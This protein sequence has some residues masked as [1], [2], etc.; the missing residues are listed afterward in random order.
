MSAYKIGFANLDEKNPF[1]VSV[2]EHLEAVAA[3]A[4]DIELIVRDN[5][6]NTERAKANAQEFAALPVDLA[7]MF[8][9]DERAG[10]EIISPLRT[11]RIPV[12]S[13]DIPILTTTFFGIDPVRAGRVAGEAM[14][15]WVNAHWGGEIEKVLVMTEYRTLDIFQQRFEHA[16]EALTERTNFN[17]KHLLNM[18]NGGQ[19]DTAAERVKMVLNG[20]WQEQHKIVIIC[21]NDKIAAGVLDGVRELQREEDVAVLSYDGTDV[22]MAEFQRPGSRFIVSPS[23]RADIYGVRLIDLARRILQGETVPP[24]NLVEPTPLTR[25]NFQQFAQP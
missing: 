13:I 11:R 21:M 5:D 10:L 9:I 16:V 7:I 25:D 2:R 18:D 4:P 3:Q 17:P 6:L 19:R 1:T 12:I 15:D 24:R 23:F 8:H 20:G 14:A 22:A